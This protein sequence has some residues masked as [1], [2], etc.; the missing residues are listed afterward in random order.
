MVFLLVLESL[1]SS[2]IENKK[3]KMIQI[4]VFWKNLSGILQQGHRYRGNKVSHETVIQ[5]K[6]LL[7]IRSKAVNTVVKLKSNVISI[8]KHLKF[9]ENNKESFVKKL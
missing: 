5:I 7:E 9:Q 1:H 8:K 4:E 6:I 3:I 2:K